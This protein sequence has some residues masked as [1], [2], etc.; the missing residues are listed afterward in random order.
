MS[1]DEV[2]HAAP[3][4]R[5]LTL[6]KI[7]KHLVPPGPTALSANTL[8]HHYRDFETVARIPLL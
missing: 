3:P 2:K 6:P 8:W 7:Y 5:I 4:E 1:A